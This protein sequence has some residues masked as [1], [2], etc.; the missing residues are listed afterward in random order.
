MNYSKTAPVKIIVLGAGGTGGWLIPHIYRIG[1]A[2]GRDLKVV[3]CDAD[4]V[5]QKNLIRQNF[6]EQDIGQV[7]SQVLAERYSSC[8]GMSCAF[9]PHFIET[10]EELSFLVRP[11]PLYVV[12]EREPQKVILIGAV[13]NIKTRKLCHQVFSKCRDL[14]YI[15]S[16]NGL[17][18]GQVVCGVR[19]SGRTIYRPL[20]EVFPEMQEIEDQYPSELSC[21]DRA[22]SEPQ[23]VTA[24]LFAASIITSF[25]YDLLVNGRLKTHFVTFN[26]ELINIRPVLYRRGSTSQIK[27][28]AA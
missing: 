16:G 19:S 9:L 6:I 23:S 11:E 8:F 5:E 1:Y 12:E 10:E 7:K 15:D 2:T 28:E 4:I 17:D 26:S 3:I 18:T 14:V 20:F 13:D 22:V 27:K 25:L 24:N 21:A